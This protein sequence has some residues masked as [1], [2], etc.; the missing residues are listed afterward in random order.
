MFSNYNQQHSLSTVRV[1]NSNMNMN[2]IFER[3][4]SRIKH[5]QAPYNQEETKIPEI[6]TSGRISVQHLNTQD[7]SSSRLGN[8]TDVTPRVY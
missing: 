3:N 6:Q 4:N 8:Q 7:L 1:S 5:M 2:K